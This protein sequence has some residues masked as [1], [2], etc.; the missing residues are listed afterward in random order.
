MIILIINIKLKF[1]NTNKLNSIKGD[2]KA[3]K[4]EGKGN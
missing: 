1:F 2:W 3:N 4:R